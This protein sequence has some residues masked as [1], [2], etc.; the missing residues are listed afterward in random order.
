MDG[1]RKTPWTA[2]RESRGGSITVELALLA[3]VMA[4]MLVG[5]I[6][7]GSYVFGKM[8]LQ[9]ASRAGAQYAIQAGRNI[10]DTAAITAAVQAASD[11]EAGTTITTQTFCGCA[12]GGEVVVD[13]REGCTG[14]ASSTLKCSGE[15]EFPVLAI[16][17]TVANTFTT[18]F[19]YP[20]IPSP[21]T[22]QGE[23]VMQV[24]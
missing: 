9:N 24:Q 11:L 23:T 19:P 20:G 17:V 2:F 1:V 5:A 15:D 7:F 16:R 3:P 18:L 8:Q 12:D 21:L 14:T 22:L 10:E 13:P 4:F 6:D